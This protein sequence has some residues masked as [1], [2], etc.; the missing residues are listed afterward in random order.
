MTKTAEIKAL[1][2]RMG[3]TPEG[4]AIV[5][6]CSPQ[7]VRNWESGLSVQPRYR[8]RLDAVAATLNAA[9]RRSLLLPTVCKPV[10]LTGVVEY[11]IGCNVTLDR[12]ENGRPVIVAQAED[13]HTVVDLRHLID[14]LKLN[15]PDLLK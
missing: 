8:E 10:T 5:V 1:R 15:K 6:G 13:G 3:L 11:C 12:H 2:K 4:F 7:T 9:A 14:W